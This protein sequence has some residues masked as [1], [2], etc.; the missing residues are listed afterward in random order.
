[1]TCRVADS[2]AIECNWSGLPPENTLTKVLRLAREI[3]PIPPIHVSLKKQIPVEAGLGGGSS[4]AAG[5]LR[6]LGREFPVALPAHTLRDIAVSVGAD[7]SFFLV[8]GLAKAEGYG[9]KLTP[10]VDF[11]K[12]WMV[13]LKPPFGTSTKEAYEKLDSVP[14]P[15]M[16]FPDTL[17][18]VYNDFER[19][20]PCVVLEAIERVRSRGARAAAL[21]GSGSCIFGR[22]SSEESARAA[23]RAL[24][25]ET[26]FESWTVPTLTREESLWM[27]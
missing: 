7:V 3:A 25:E 6:W 13:I 14:F 15:W 11:A 12:D 23:E 17:D 9:E 22:F 26:G 18:R 16:D 21:C 27:S 2:D 5:L 1:M 19:V 8:G 24:A 4:N 20:M 10:L